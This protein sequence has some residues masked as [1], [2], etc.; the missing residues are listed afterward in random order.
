MATKDPDSNADGDG[1]APTV[2]DDGEQLTAEL[3]T[4]D[5]GTR[6]CTIYPAHVG[7]DERTAAWIRAD[8]DSFVNA[9]DRC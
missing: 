4:T 2:R 3:A 8:E 6:V 1:G 5:A 7:D 9:S